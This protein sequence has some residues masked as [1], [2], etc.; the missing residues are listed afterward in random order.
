[1]SGFFQINQNGRRADVYLFGSITR[2]PWIRGD[3]SA[4]TMVDELKQLDADEIHL[5]INSMGGS[6]PEGWAMYN[7]LCEH[8]ARITTYADGFVASAALYPFLAGDERIA[9]GTS[10]FFFHEAATYAEGYADDLRKAADQVALV[11][12]IG[13]NAFVERTGQTQEYIRELMKKETW[14]PPEDALAMGLATSIRAAEPGA[15]YAQDAAK[16]LFRALQQK[17]DPPKPE[18]KIKKFFA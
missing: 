13:I 7:A 14:M 6:V 1:M 9:N 4:A 16:C 10:V 8:P 2:Y 3:K 11:T 5:H 17:A 18:N 12:D 15:V